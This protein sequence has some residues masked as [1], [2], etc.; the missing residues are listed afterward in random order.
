MAEKLTI[1][2]QLGGSYIEINGLLYPMFD[3]PTIKSGNVRIGKYGHIWM[4]Y[5]KENY[6]DRYRNL[7]R[8]GIV[9][10]KVSEINEEAYE[11]LDTISEQ[12][13]KREMPEGCDSTLDM[14]KVREQARQVAEE[15]V[16]Q[17]VVLRRR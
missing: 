2:E 6:P 16:L 13:I 5:M 15:I 1:F 9:E 12:Y 4:N 8:R 7:F 3:K 14:W 17:E 11:L 10:I